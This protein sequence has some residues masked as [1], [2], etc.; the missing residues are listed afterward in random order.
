MKGIYKITLQN[1]C[2]YVGQSID[3]KKR[4][5]GHIRKLKKGTHDNIYLQRLYNKYSKDFVFEIIEEIANEKLLTER[6]NYW[7]NLLSPSCNMQIPTDSIHFTIT[8]ES[9]KRMSD[10]TKRRMTPEMRKLISKRT[11]EAMA[12]PEVRKAF[13]IG[14]KNKKN[15]T[16]WNKGLKGKYHA[17][18]RKKVYCPELD[19]EFESAL[20]AGKYLGVNNSKGVSRVCLGQRNVFKGKHWYYID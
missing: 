13:I 9:R 16:A 10:A 18:N 6:E 17:P 20:A 12:R 3:I 11:K 14:Q 5:Q 2:I 19:M 15:K 7:I 1:K 8:E 4:W